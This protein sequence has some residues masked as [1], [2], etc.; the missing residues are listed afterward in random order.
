MP[1]IEPLQQAHGQ[2]AA[3]GAGDHFQR[4]PATREPELAG[5]PTIVLPAAFW[6]FGGFLVG[7]IFWHFIGFWSFVGDVVFS[8]RPPA[9]Y[10]EIAQTGPHCIE[11]VLDRASGAVRGLPCAL[12]VP[13]LDES[14]NAVKGDYLGH[15]KHLA[16]APRGPQPVKLTSGER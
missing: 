5:E 10:R 3:P 8:S 6:G 13:R 16:R 7:A 9:E 1:E 15:R 2:A 11:L 12:E 14:A 4:D